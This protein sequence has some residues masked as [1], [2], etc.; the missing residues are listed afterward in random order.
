METNTLLYKSIR[1]LSNLIKQKEIKASEVGKYFFN[2]ISSLGP[3]LNSV[4]SLLPELAE[5]SWN[6][7]D[8]QNEIKTILHGIPYGIKDLISVSYKDS[9]LSN[10]NSPP[11][12]WGAKPLANQH[13]ENTATIVKRLN[14]DK[15]IPLAKLAM[16]ELAGGLGY[17][18]PNASLTGPGLNPWDTSKWT[19][20]S[21]SGSGAAVAAGLV[22]FALGTETWGSI[23]TPA[24]YCGITGLR[25]TLGLVSRNGAMALSWTLDKIGPMCL[26]ADD[27]GIVLDTISGYDP[28]DSSSSRKRFTYEPEFSLK[29]KPKIAIFKGILETCDEDVKNNFNESVKIL[30][31]FTEIE[32]IDLPEY[33]Y[34]IVTRIIL[35]SESTSAMEDFIDDDLASTLTAPED[36]YSIFPRTLISAKDYIKALRMRKVIVGIVSNIY[37]QY[38]AIIAPTKPSTAPP[39]DG[40]FRGSVRSGY[41]PMGSIGNLTGLPA[42]SVPNGFGIKD[43]MPT[44]FQIMGQPFSENLLIGI[45]K[46]YQNV[47]KWHLEHPKKYSGG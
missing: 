34:E 19:G 26:N 13:F 22:P 46:E 2:R 23:L 44:G 37:K 17:K 35:F 3:E 1:Q 31:Q 40:E 12:T 27:C 18:Q 4:V 25:P 15:A 33:P 38:D 43:T 16:V 9:G 6:S 29:N 20:G 8:K 7:A 28:K 39:S 30:S 41:D 24:V 10:V 11:T 42:I 47:T 5:K 14:R 45:A 36:R 21:S 32:E